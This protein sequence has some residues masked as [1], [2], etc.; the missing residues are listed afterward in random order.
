VVHL[1][2]K[3]MLGLSFRCLTT[4]A[5]LIVATCWL[6]RTHRQISWAFFCFTYFYSKLVV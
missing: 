5:E 3:R 6:A 2:M 1:Y 4:V